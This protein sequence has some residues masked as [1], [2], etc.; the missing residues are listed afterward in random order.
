MTQ[1]IKK[2]AR[3]MRDLEGLL[4]VCMRCGTCQSVCPLF[5][6]TGRES[7][8][9]RGKLA[10]LDGLMLEMFRNPAGV[11]ERLNKCLLCGSCAANCPAGVKAPEIFLKARAILTDYMGL[12]PIKQLLLRGMLARPAVFDRLAEHGAVFQKFFT[13]P[14]NPLIGTSCARFVPQI[15]GNRHFIPPAPIPFHRITPFL[16]TPSGRAGIRAAFYVGCLTDKFFPRVAQAAT[17]VLTH[18]GVGIFMPENQG[19]CGI[20]ALACGDTETFL[21]LL[22][23]NL[24]KFGT[25]TFDYLITPCATCTYTIKK[26]WP[27][28]SKDAPGNICLKSKEIAEKTL[29]IHQFLVL[30]TDLGTSRQPAPASHQADKTI[31]VTCHDPCHLKKSLGVSAEPRAVI[32]ANPAYHLTE[33]PE[34]DR[35]CGLGG[36]FSLHYYDLSAEIGRR[37]RDNI[38]STACSTVAAGCPACMMQLSDMLSRAGDNV[39]VKHPIEIYAEMLKAGQ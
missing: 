36:S 27:M 7:D 9:A 30:K 38:V 2:L 22:C 31:S 5:A 6:E 12:S 8:V 17:D 16:N 24:E 3:Q 28:M 39:V 34:A 23:H 37:K 4:N 29:D 32:Q 18:H 11:N 1:D 26:I 20:P 14:A 21:R 15:I 33:M 35:C 19:C 10:M 13:K 25:E